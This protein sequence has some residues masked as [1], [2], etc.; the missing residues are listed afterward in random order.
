MNFRLA[1]WNFTYIDD[2][3]VFANGKEFSENMIDGFS[4][5]VSYSEAK[6]YVKQRT[7]NNEKKQICRAIIVDGHAVGGVDLFIGDGTSSKSADAVL[8][9]AKEYRNQGIATETIKQ[10]CS[11]A[12]ENYDIVRI[13]A[14]PYSDD[15]VSAKVFTKAGFECEG[16]LKKAL[17][18]N[19]KFYDYC[20]FALLKR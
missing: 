6:Y 18:K 20:I 10:I 12:F 9:V 8:W 4:Y 16:T 3:A 7:L 11:Y 13:S 5:P 17:Y 2:V 19:G 14:T 15:T 1:K